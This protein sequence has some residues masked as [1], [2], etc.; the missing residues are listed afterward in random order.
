MPFCPQSPLRWHFTAPLWQR[1]PP[2]G[3]RDAGNR[4]LAERPRVR[5]G[6]DELVVNASR[7]LLLLF[8]MTPVFPTC[9][10]ESSASAM[11]RPGLVF[12]AAPGLY[13]HVGHRA[14]Q[15]HEPAHGRG[16]P[17]S[18]RIR[19]QLTRGCSQSSPETR[20]ASRASRCRC[21]TGRSHGPNRPTGPKARDQIA[22]RPGVLQDAKDRSLHSARHEDGVEGLVAAEPGGI[23][24]TPC[25]RCRSSILPHLCRRVARPAHEPLLKQM[26]LCGV[27]GARR[28]APRRGRG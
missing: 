26:R 22:G 10:G 5:R 20:T 7:P 3:W 17:S 18:S 12:L 9:R 13:G 21:Q 28:N 11:P 24:R 6:T 16:A 8:A 4:L 25:C 14:L 23:A 1:S 19:R 2:T 27:I 15:I